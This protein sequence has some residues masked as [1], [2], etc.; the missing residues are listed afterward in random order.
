MP[1][2]IV[3]STIYLEDKRS[4]EDDRSAKKR[5]CQGSCIRGSAINGE[6]ILAL[7]GAISDTQKIRTFGC[8]SARAEDVGL[9]GS[10]KIKEAGAERNSTT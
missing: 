7:I 3:N 1:V 4:E 10:N 6:L 2:P 9:G 8:V 5:H